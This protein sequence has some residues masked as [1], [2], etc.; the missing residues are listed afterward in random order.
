MRHLT[1]L[2]H[3]PDRS[4]IVI[5]A[6]RAVP[7]RR[8]S[9]RLKRTRAGIQE[10]QRLLALTESESARSSKYI[11]DDYSPKFFGIDSRARR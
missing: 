2:R 8:I 11:S 9:L 6:E 10:T 1:N 5:P 7:Q 4:Q 3:N